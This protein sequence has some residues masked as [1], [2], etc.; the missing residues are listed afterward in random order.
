VQ[1]VGLVDEL[2]ETVDQRADGRRVRVVRVLR[3]TTIPEDVLRQ[4]WEMPSG[5]VPPEVARPRVSLDPWRRGATPP[6]RMDRVP[7]RRSG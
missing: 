7:Q 6:G 5:I 3:A 2:V 4:A 1:E